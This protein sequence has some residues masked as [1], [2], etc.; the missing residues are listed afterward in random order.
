MPEP[1][2]QAPSIERPEPSGE[3]RVTVVTRLRDTAQLGK[4]IDSVLSQSH[5]NLEYLLV[6]FESSRQ[7]LALA[8][9]YARRDSRVRILR[10]DR[11]LSMMDCYNVALAEIDPESAYFKIVDAADLLFPFCLR[12]MM[13]V[14]ETAPNVAIV[15]SYRLRGTEIDGLGLD[16]NRTVVTGRE[17]C[18]LH[19][20]DGI[21]LF[22]SPMRLLFRSEL[23][24][25]R[26]PFFASGRQHADTEAVF[27]ILANRDFG[28]VHRSLGSSSAEPEAGKR[29]GLVIGASALD[30]FI[31]VSQYGPVYLDPK[32]YALCLKGAMRWYYS[33]LARAWMMERVGHSQDGFWSYHRD[34]LRT[35]GEAIRPELLALALARLTAGKLLAPWRAL[36]GI[37]EEPE[38]FRRRT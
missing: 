23:L 33:V 8:E 13:A 30:R 38:S 19:L 18:R 15:S 4:C 24:A 17:A 14:A 11:S 34:G 28:F 20:L 32:E 16:P 27:E 2:T 25:D 12:E 31:V 3:P 9:E 35:I 6:D 7:A 22:G 26:Q 37:E 10:T 5:R 29:A 1:T 21:F 36:R